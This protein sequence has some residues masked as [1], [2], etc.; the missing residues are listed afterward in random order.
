MELLPV[1]NYE[2]LTFSLTETGYFDTSQ[3]K[4]IIRQRV[5]L[6]QNKMHLSIFNLSRPKNV[7]DMISSRRSRMLFAV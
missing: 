7:V 6:L 5:Y 1:S 4:G 3:P 2:P